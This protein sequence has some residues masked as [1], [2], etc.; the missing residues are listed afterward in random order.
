[1]V[2]G[3]T[4][5]DGDPVT[6]NVDSIFQDEPVNNEGDGNTAPD[7][8]GLGTSVAQVRSE[9]D[10]EGNGRFYHIGFTA[11]DEM[12]NSCTGTVKVSVLANKG[13]EGAAVDD[14]PLYDATIAEP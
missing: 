10:G 12:G 9:R 4:D 7:A 14:G 8:D 1:M 3:V 2:L 5:P 6:I 13:N 11:T